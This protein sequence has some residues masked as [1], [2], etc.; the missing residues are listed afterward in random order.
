VFHPAIGAQM[1]VGVVGQ[2]QL[3]VLISRLE[4]E[5]KVDARLEPSPWE[6][7]RWVSADT[8]ADLR[9]SRAITAA[10]WRRTVTPSRCSWPR[11]SG[12]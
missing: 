1:I 7:A 10:R 2:L 6:T 4:H 11:T 12:T 3:E 8:P 5:Y 9:R